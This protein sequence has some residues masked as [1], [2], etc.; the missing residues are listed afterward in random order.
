MTNF[1]IKCE[2][3]PFLSFLKNSVWHFYF[4]SSYLNTEASEALGDVLELQ[5]GWGKVLNLHMEENT[6]E[7]RKLQKN[8]QENGNILE[9]LALEP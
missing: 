6:P 2:S 9:S 5:D 4:L 1:L 8:F 3:N 7:N